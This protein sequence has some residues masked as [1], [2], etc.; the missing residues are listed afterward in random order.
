MKRL[1]VILASLLIVLALAQPASAD[2]DFGQ[3]QYGWPKKI[4]S[5]FIYAHAWG[6]RIDGRLTVVGATWSRVEVQNIIFWENCNPG[7]H[8]VTDSGP[9]TIYP[10]GDQTW[11]TRD[12]T[13][14]H[15][16][17]PYAAHIEAIYRIFWKSGGSTALRDDNSYNFGVT[18]QAC[19]DSG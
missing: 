7:C 3:R 14:I 19:A 5:S 16:T 15:G 1:A 2:T 6:Y 13:C 11:T 10:G 17:M 4:T 18:R 9:S 12:V 8:K